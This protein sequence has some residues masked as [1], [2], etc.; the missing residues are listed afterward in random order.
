MSVPISS[1]EGEF[2]H[3]LDKKLRVSVPA[4]WRPQQGSSY[5]LRLIKWEVQGIPIIKAMT[6]EAFRAAIDSIQNN[7]NLPN[8]IKNRQKGVLF[9]HNQPVTVNG[10]GKML[11]PKKFAEERGVEPES[12]VHLFGRGSSFEIVTPANYEALIENEKEVL[13]GLYDSLNH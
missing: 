7:P 3:K 2:E 5:S 11:I 9:S 8:G 6:E 10:Q 1:F 12:T 4:S 13:S